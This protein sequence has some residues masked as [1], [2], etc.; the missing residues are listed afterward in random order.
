MKYLV[1]S[2]PMNISINFENMNIMLNHDDDFLEIKRS[3]LMNKN[4]ENLLVLALTIN[5]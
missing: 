2:F 4:L 3:N 5:H 1:K